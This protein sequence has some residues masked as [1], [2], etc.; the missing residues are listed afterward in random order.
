MDPIE[1]FVGLSVTQHGVMFEHVQTTSTHETAT[2]GTIDF[3]H[4]AFQCVPKQLQVFGIEACVTREVRIDEA[5]AK[6]QAIWN[7]V[8]AVLSAFAFPSFSS[9]ADVA[10][11]A[12]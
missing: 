4:R 12:R 6:I 10:S 7:G 5:M 11:T 1:E 8:L 2:G 9:F 3:P